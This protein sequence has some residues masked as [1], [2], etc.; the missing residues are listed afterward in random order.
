[1]TL[2]TVEALGDKAL[3]TRNINHFIKYNYYFIR[4]MQDSLQ[5]AGFI[6]HQEIENTDRMLQEL[7]RLLI[8]AENLST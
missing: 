4:S 3:D 2:E 8:R 1:M 5:D 6:Q 7:Q